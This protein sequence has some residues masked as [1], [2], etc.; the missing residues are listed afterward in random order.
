MIESYYIP[1][2]K[3]N[4]KISEIV[5]PGCFI[6]IESYRYEQL[7]RKPR[8]RSISRK[9]LNTSTNERFIIYS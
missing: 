1:S 3:V 6:E 8:G 4:F 2:T 7:S 5:I 9:L